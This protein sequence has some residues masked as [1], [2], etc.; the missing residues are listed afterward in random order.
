[1]MLMA[2]TM[3]E[4]F[5]DPERLVYH[6]TNA[7]TV[8]QRILKDRTLKLGSYCSTDDPAE[9]ST[10]LFDFITYQN[11]DLAPYNRDEISTWLSAALKQRT[12]L[13]CFSTDAAPL[14]GDHIGDIARR[15]F[16][17]PRMWSQRADC[18]RGVCLAFDRTVL[19]QAIADQFGNRCLILRGNV[20]YR[21]RSIMPL[22]D[23]QPYRVNI[24]V[25][26][27]IGRQ[28]YVRAHLEQFKQQ[29]FFEKMV[30]WRDEAEYRWVLLTDTTEDLFVPF[31]GALVGIVFGERTEPAAIDRMMAMTES[32]GLDR[33][34]LKWS[35]ASPWYDY[36]N[37]RYWRV[38]P[39]D[40][41]GKKA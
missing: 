21:N 12:K 29:L 30:D 20:N 28:A 41:A 14:T 8:E 6:Y 40:G 17:R 23:G 36:A 25:L 32:W 1:M 39:T 24:D 10:W 34:G 18:H 15:G 16:C 19:H 22:E 4:R 3:F 13:A 35:N 26:E 31:G 33:I 37:R 27:S 5:R 11:R 7:S 2:A 9:T 38:I